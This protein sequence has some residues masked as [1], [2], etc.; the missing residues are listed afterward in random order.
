[1]RQTSVKGTED[2]LILNLGP[3]TELIG[4]IM[5]TGRV[6]YELVYEKEMSGEE[7]IDFLKRHGLFEKHGE[8]VDISKKY[9]V[10]SY[11]W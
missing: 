4:E 9:T 1:M 10:T 3:D 7:L 5:E 2:N 6:K 8:K 11:D